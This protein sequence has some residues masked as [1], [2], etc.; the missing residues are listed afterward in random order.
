MRPL[1][2][3]TFVSSFHANKTWSSS[4]TSSTIRFCTPFAANVLCMVCLVKGFASFPQLFFA[5][6]FFVNPFNSVAVVVTKNKIV[7]YVV[8]SDELFTSAL[9]CRPR[10]EELFGSSVSHILARLSVQ[11]HPFH[12]PCSAVFTERGLAMG[13]THNAEICDR[14]FHLFVVFP[15]TLLVKSRTDQALLILSLP[16]CSEFSFDLLIV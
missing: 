16:I 15:Y 14:D 7:S 13:N 5:Q 11:H 3:C 12:C 9:R 6:V 8:K 4:K 1:F 2:L 10:H